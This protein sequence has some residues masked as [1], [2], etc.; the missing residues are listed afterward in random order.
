LLGVVT[1][2][3]FWPVTR[4]GFVNVDDDLYIYDNPHIRAG[5]GSTITWA[6]TSFHAGNWHPLTWLS[7]AADYQ[8]FGLSPSGHHLVN[9]LFHT[10]NAL[11]LFLLLRQMTGALWRS[12]LVAALFAWHPL[13][14]ESVAWASERK[15]VLSTFFWLLSMSAYVR[16]VR[17]CPPLCPSLSCTSSNTIT[18]SAAPDS[19]IQRFNGSTPPVPTLRCSDAPALYYFLS[20]F[21]FA[22]GLLSKPMVVT[23]PCVL[24]L[25]D[26]WPLRRLPGTKISRLVGEKIPF[27]ALTIA[28]CIITCLVQ[29][30]AASSLQELPLMSRLAN[31]SLAYFG[32]LLKTFWPANLSA[33]YPLPAQVQVGW[34]VLAIL[35]LVAAS[36]CFIAGARRQPYMLIGWLWFLGTLVPTIGLVQVGAQALADRYT[37]IPSVGLFLVIVWSVAEVI[38]RWPVTRTAFAAM[39]SA[40]LIACLLLTRLQTGYWRDSATLYQHAIDVT[41]DNVVAYDHLGKAFLDQGDLE[42]AAV[43]FTQATKLTPVDAEAHYKLGSVR[44]MQSNLDAATPEFMEALRLNPNYAE[45]HRNLAIILMRQGKLPEGLAHFAETLRIRPDDPDAHFNLGVAHLQLNEPAEAEKCFRAALKLQPDNAKTQY[46]LA[47]VCLQQNQFA[48]AHVAAQKAR[49]LALAD[50]Q[51]ELAANAQAIIKRSTTDPAHSGAAR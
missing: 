31:A 43:N 4:D 7:H 5:V 17:A 21:L 14:V 47:V 12:A 44:L 9:L 41:K 8:L 18:F 11:L 20:F 45:A 33:I 37:Y 34:I 29:K 3:V 32:Y 36:F 39:G 42:R 23:L 22:L 46:H 50:G 2:T 49:D 38:E 25:V 48:D 19:T 27:F 51:T 15:D 30:G 1:I 40:A 13:H 24:L 35:I 28:V 10:A 6:A 26:F 16:Y